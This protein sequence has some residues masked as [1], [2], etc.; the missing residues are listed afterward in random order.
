MSSKVG[1]RAIALVLGS[2]P[3]REL[4]RNGLSG[5]SHASVLAHQNCP[6]RRYAELS[7]VTGVKVYLLL[8]PT[9]PMATRHL[10]EY[11]WFATLDLSV[12]SQEELDAI[13]IAC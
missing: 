10:R 3:F 4:A 7:T 1:E 9:Q 8:R 13:R 11:Q 2:A 12:H 5:H 6:M